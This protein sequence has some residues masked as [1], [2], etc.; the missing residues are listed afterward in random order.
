MASR[1]TIA[2]EQTPPPWR[3]S[4]FSFFAKQTSN[5]NKS[6][7][8]PAATGYRMFWMGNEYYYLSQDIVMNTKKERIRDEI[9]AEEVSRRRRRRIL[10]A[11]VR[12]ELQMETEYSTRVREG[13]D[14]S[15]AKVG[16]LLEPTKGNPLLGEA[17]KGLSLLEEKIALLFAEESLRLLRPKYGVDQD[18]QRFDVASINRRR[19]LCL[20]LNQWPAIANYSGGGT[21]R[22]A[23]SS[24]PAVE[25]EE[26]SSR[27][28][29]RR[30]I[31]VWSCDI[32]EVSTT[33][34]LG[35]TEHFQGKKHKSK[36]A[37]VT[38]LKH[39]NSDIIDKLGG[40]ALEIDQSVEKKIG[41]EHENVM[42]D[43][44]KA[45]ETHLVTELDLERFTGSKPPLEKKRD[46][47]ED[48][49][50]CPGSSTYT[51]AAAVYQF[52][53]ARI[54]CSILKE[55]ATAITEENTL[56]LMS[57]SMNSFLMRQKNVEEKLARV[58]LEKKLIE[59]EKMIQEDAWK[60][61]LEFAA[62]E[63]ELASLQAKY[64]KLEAKMREYRESHVSKTDLQ[65]W[66][67]AFSSR[68]LPTSGMANVMFGINEV[69]KRL[70]GHGVAVAALERME[71]G[72]T[73][74][75]G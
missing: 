69:A 37:L 59:Q 43:H 52:G 45:P 1:C 51:T 74:N 36:E 19:R 57:T 54:E 12:A 17:N 11:G 60:E 23:K 44:R 29:K 42:E 25:E 15:P 16:I 63:K 34:E 31:G 62:K 46:A 3:Q 18:Q 40:D 39:E 73:I 49:A 67:V 41:A 35:L 56:K 50:A 75:A 58:E 55:N 72:R 22:K 9:I 26:A 13:G 38:K 32:C 53:D 20:W 7:Q 65:Q 14:T 8:F 48:T 64:I 71:K 24:C 5:G 4:N 27:G 2:E 21:K 68:M 70:G 6:K 66:L 30:N 10:E 61:Q 47:L 28:K 33:S